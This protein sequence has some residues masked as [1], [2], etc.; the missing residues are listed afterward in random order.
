MGKFTKHKVTILQGVLGDMAVEQLGWLSQEEQDK[1]WSDHEAHVKDL[2]ERGEYLKPITYDV[3]MEVDPLYDSYRD[4]NGPV[5]E[6]YR[7]DILNFGS[8]E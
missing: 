6:S 1:F 8:D 4:P 2:K 7:Y 3:E 5:V